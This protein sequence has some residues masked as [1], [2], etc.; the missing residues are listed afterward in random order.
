[1]EI[2]IA[3]L[4]PDVLNMYGDKGNIITLKYR[5]EKRGII[6]NVN[7][8]FANDSIDFENTDIIYIGGGSDKCYENIY[9]YLLPQKQQFASYIENGGC[10]LAV[11]TGYQ[12]LGTEC[13][14]EDKTLPGL[15]ILDISTKKAKKLIG[16]I[17]MECPLTQSKITGFINKNH[18]ISGGNYDILG[19]AV[20][21]ESFDEGTVYKNVIA[22]YVYGPLLP[23]NP[24]LADMILKNAVTKKY[25]D[26]VIL[27]KLNDDLEQKAS[28]YII[29]KYSK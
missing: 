11:C 15:G 12:L 17:V 16:D 6:A 13:E 18:V 1:M 25:G 26:D 10:V 2:N 20:Y 21:P 28:E 19:T 27:E 7:E 8:Y 23:K 5:L 29:N 4:Y 9:S 22:T 24:K 14:F 3:C